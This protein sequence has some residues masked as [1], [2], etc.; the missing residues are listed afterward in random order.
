MALCGGKKELCY[1]LT[2]GESKCNARGAQ[3]VDMIRVAASPLNS[4]SLYGTLE[5]LTN[6]LEN[7]AYAEQ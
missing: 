5:M 1:K 2:S 6:L 4:M 3:V 7:S